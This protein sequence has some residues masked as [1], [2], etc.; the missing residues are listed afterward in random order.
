MAI[1]R[2]DILDT[3]PTLKVCTAY[4]LNGKVINFFPA[5]IGVLGK[6]EPIYEELPGWLTPTEN[7]RNYKYLPLAAQNYVKCL[8]ELAGCTADLICVGPA[9]E[10]TIE[11]SAII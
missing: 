10:Q 4:K 2:F 8:E 5:S 6:C 7:V 3:M 1:T 11:K 9:R